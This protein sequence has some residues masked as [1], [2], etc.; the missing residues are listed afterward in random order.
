MNES[1]KHIIS[2][3]G[4]TSAGEEAGELST[5]NTKVVQLLK[6]L[7]ELRDADIL[8]EEEFQSK[9]QE[10]LP[11]IR[12]RMECQVHV[13]HPTQWGYAISVD[14]EFIAIKETGNMLSDDVSSNIFIYDVEGNQVAKLASHGGGEYGVAFWPNSRHIIASGCGQ[15]PDWNADGVKQWR[16]DQRTKSSDWCH[17]FS[18]SPLSGIRVNIVG[19]SPKGRFVLG[20]IDDGEGWILDANTRKS[21]KASWLETWDR[22]VFT[23][24]ERYTGVARGLGT[25]TGLGMIVDNTSGEIVWQKDR[26]QVL[27]FSPENRHFLS[28]AEASRDHQIALWDVD[29]F[30]RHA[31]LE[32]SQHGPKYGFYAAAFSNDG[33]RL[34][35]AAADGNQV[36]VFDASSLS[37]IDRFFLHGTGDCLAVAMKYSRQGKL[38]VIEQGLGSRESHISVWN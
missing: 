37:L 8:T 15:P 27:A 19:A 11:E 18:S 4:M 1:G 6:Q 30:E 14:G 32:L 25:R 36:L 7:K 5:R 38:I 3:E 33:N 10:L 20:N 16:V 2:S 28:C 31:E 21:K 24:D 12:V 22:L 13:R 26:H 17:V 9:K 35:V 34:A 29:S 23:S